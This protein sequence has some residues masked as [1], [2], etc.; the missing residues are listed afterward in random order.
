MA[1]R[2]HIGAIAVLAITLCAAGAAHAQSNELSQ[3]ILS[4]PSRPIANG[5]L[6]DDARLFGGLVDALITNVTGAADDFGD[7]DLISF[8]IVPRNG[9]APPE[10]LGFTTPFVG[11]RDEFERWARDNAASLLAVLF[12]GGLSAGA[13]GRD[14]GALYSQQL[15]LT[16]ILD[17]NDT[18]ARG[19]LGAG[20]LVES[21]W[22]RHDVREAGD[23]AWGIQGLYGFSPHLSL[24]A[25]FGNQRETLRTSA[26]S[27]AVDYHPFIERGS[28][29]RFR[30]GASA[31]SGFLY[32]SSQSASAVQPDALR[33]GSIDIAGGGWASARRRF[34]DLTVG[35]GA[36][37]MG[38]KSYVPPG[39]EGTFRSAFAHALNDRGI[40]Y[41]LTVGGTARFDA[42]NR[43]SLIGRLAETYGLDSAT[44]RPAT[45]LVL[46]GV[47]FALAP[48]ASLDAGYKVTSFGDTLAQSVFFQGNFGW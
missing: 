4:L 27:V 38:T 3:A 17:V 48:G 44:D 11:T 43:V 19:R 41:D 13:A 37:L 35:G 15:L 28:T 36:M 23:S 25:R 26:T 42:T 45:H 14:V 39:E 22:L 5:R 33:F 16:T 1:T 12:P 10:G 8:R 18:Q 7:G 30:V 31:R 2:S 32:S 46:G 21:E 29:T 34:G 24:Q 6:F 20:G 40:A 47:M 9:N